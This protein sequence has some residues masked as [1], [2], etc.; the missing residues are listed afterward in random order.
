ML[1]TQT[2]LDDL[3]QDDK[4]WR[5]ISSDHYYYQTPHTL[6]VQLEDAEGAEIQFQPQSVLDSGDSVLLSSDL[7]GTKT[8][9]KITGAMQSK[10]FE[11][12]AGSFY[13]HYPVQGSDLVGFGFNS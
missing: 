4:D 2:W 5:M 6:F 13:I 11:Y 1:L 7:A 8:L 9:K 3:V 10:K 12:E